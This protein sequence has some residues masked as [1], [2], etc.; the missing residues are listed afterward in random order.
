MSGSIDAC[1]ALRQE[2]IAQPMH[3]V[4]SYQESCHSPSA[5]NGYNGVTEYNRGHFQSCSAATR[6]KGKPE[7]RASEAWLDVCRARAKRL[8][9]DGT[10]EDGAARYES[11]V[12]RAHPGNSARGRLRD[13]RNLA[14]A[15]RERAR[16]PAAVD[17]VYDEESLSKEAHR[18]RARVTP[19]AR[20]RSQ[21]PNCTTWWKGGRVGEIGGV[22]C[23]ES[24]TGERGEVCVDAVR[25]RISP[26][27]E[28]W[29]NRHG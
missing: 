27:I 21:S 3:R 24:T 5:G 14:S 15:Y 4:V 8:H 23:I 11:E 10:R 25:H 29:A 20:M 1:A 19:L 26:V 16:Q 17:H 6:K 28:Q 2:E 13:E 7:I 18:S 22:C 9:G 12:I